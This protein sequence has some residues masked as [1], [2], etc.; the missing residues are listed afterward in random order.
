M[1]LPATRKTA[2][3]EDRGEDNKDPDWL[4][5][6]SVWDKLLEG[7]Y[8]VQ[9]RLKVSAIVTKS[10][11]EFYSVQH[12]AQQK[13][14]E[15]SCRG[16]ITPYNSSA[17]CVAT[18]LRDKLLRKLQCNTTLKIDAFSGIGDQS[19]SC[20]RNK[21]KQTKQDKNSINMCSGLYAHNLFSLKC[22]Q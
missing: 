6:Q 5:E 7:C 21:N 2:T 11:T 22:S 20:V 12:C 8:T 19:E 15:T 1:G 14:C 9:R 3:E 16:N 10:R 18:V 13:C 4:I 17:T